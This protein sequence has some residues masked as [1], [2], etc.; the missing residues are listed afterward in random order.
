MLRI[1]LTLKWE[2]RHSWGGIPL[3]DSGEPLRRLQEV[4]AR[5]YGVKE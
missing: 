3:P 2:N 4:K 1:V 5:E